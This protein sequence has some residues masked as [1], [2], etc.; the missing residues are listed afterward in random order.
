MVPVW[1]NCR[2]LGGSTSSVCF[3]SLSR[4]HFL[5]CGLLK[6]TFNNEDNAKQ[7]TY[8]Y[9]GWHVRAVNRHERS[10]NTKIAVEA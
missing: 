1:F 3:S 5:L 7:V 6:L 4:W 2:R 9:P 8:L 10:S